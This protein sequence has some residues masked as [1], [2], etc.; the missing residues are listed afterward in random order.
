M[1]L[2]AG[3]VEDALAVVGDRRTHQPRVDVVPDIGRVPASRAT[4]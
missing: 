2:R 1:R 3:N 4:A